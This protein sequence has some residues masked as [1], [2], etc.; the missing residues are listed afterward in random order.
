[1]KLSVT[2]PAQFPW[3][4]GHCS[5]WRD[6]F[7]S[8][9]G[10]WRNFA[11]CL[12][13]ERYLSGEPC[14]ISDVDTDRA[15]AIL[16]ACLPRTGNCPFSFELVLYSYDLC[17][18]SD[19]NSKSRCGL[20]I[21]ELLVG[22]S[23]RWHDAYIELHGSGLPVLYMVKDKLPMLRSLR[24]A[25]WFPDEH[26]GSM[27][28]PSP[29]HAD[30]FENTPQ[31]RCLHLCEITSWRVDWSCL[32]VV[33]LWYPDTLEMHLGRLSRISRLEELN[34]YG[35]FRD[36]VLPGTASLTLPYLKILRIGCECI[37]LL[38]RTPILQELS[39]IRRIYI[40][41]SETNGSFSDIISIYLPFLPHLTKLTL[42]TDN[43]RD[44]EA[45]LQYMPTVSDLCLYF[46]ASNYARLVSGRPAE[47]CLYTCT[48]SILRLLSECPK[49]RCLKSLTVGLLQND[50]YYLAD[51]ITWMKRKSLPVGVHRFDKLEHLS[52]VFDAWA[53]TNFFDV[54]EEIL[55]ADGIPTSIRKINNE[56]DSII[57]DFFECR[58]L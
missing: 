9:P 35:R 43:T 22:Q 28:D 31:L 51:I 58:G 45:L 50:K 19:Q 23:T 44:V 16:I 27:D 49:A 37:P 18:S 25:M 48:G 41:P 14:A 2:E 26:G 29:T 36:L 30:L 5:P 20:Q 15:L 24:V 7:L 8:Y 54:L 4:L 55:R 52:L 17:H 1:M 21:L 3:Y 42:C 13:P 11:I 53:D 40:T 39:I 46:C 10:F 32:T 38:F 33:H 34:I 56:D 12:E 57:L 6:V 47:Y